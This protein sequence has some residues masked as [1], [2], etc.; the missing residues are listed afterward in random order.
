MTAGAP[1][2]T[3]PSPSA[4][5]LASSASRG[6][7]ARGLGVNVPGV[8]PYAPPGH[9]VHAPRSGVTI[10]KRTARH[11]QAAAGTKATTPSPTEQA[12]VS[13]DL[14]AVGS[15]WTRA[16]VGPS[17]YDRSASPRRPSTSGRRRLRCDAGSVRASSPLPW[18]WSSRSTIGV[19]PY[20]LFLCCCF[21]FLGF[22]SNCMY[23]GGPQF[24]T[25]ELQG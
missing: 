22:H 18:G 19:P 5:S 8:G 14:D 21:S 16:P 7:A 9:E 3:P 2:L 4:I 15:G 20:Q 11:G 25:I 23:I 12:K 24:R 1:R 6:A 10:A 13:P 17:S